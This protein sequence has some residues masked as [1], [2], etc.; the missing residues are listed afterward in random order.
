M[1]ER[2]R[3]TDMERISQGCL[4]FCPCVL[5]PA[6]MVSALTPG[7]VA[8]NPLSKFHLSPKGHFCTPNCLHYFSLIV[9][10]CILGMAVIKANRIYSLL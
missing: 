10:D 9:S 4:G 1:N 3:Q 7:K 6:N 5:S 2:Y 8:P